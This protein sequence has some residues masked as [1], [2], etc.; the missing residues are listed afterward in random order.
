MITIK[1][2][3]KEAGVAISTVSNILNNPTGKIKASE[4]TQKKV[5][6][7]V[8]KYG[9]K[10]CMF[11]KSLRDGR[12]YTVAVVGQTA[13]Y[14]RNIAYCLSGIE[15]YLNELSYSVLFVSTK[16]RDTESY[17]N[18]IEKILQRKIDGVIIIEKLNEM[19]LEYFKTLANQVPTI[20]VFKD[21]G[22]ENIKSV[23]V[24]GEKIGRLGAEYLYE[25]GHRKV[26]LLGNRP[27]IKETLL[28][29]WGE[30]GLTLDEKYFLPD[31]EDFESG[32][33]ALNLVVDGK[34]DATAIFCYNDNNAAG[35]LY[36]AN[37]LKVN[38]PAEL[39]VLGVNNLDISEKIYPKLTTIEI[40]NISQGIE[41]AR[42]LMRVIDK[43]IAHNQ[44][45]A[46]TLI[47]R[48]SCKKIKI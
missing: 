40:P 10:P 44:I 39:S 20:K 35:V 22:V 30:H 12:S 42:L 34:I 25:L 16:S 46:P 4:V 7:I 41:A 48:D 11:G 24:D 3:A 47:E 43:K 14:D 18:C 9:Y 1:E 38:V 27:A 2:I 28:K 5:L 19:N 17:Q 13:H 36:E 23:Y 21:S 32:R 29:V 26:L 33:K 31:F 37:R 6:E 45:L 8:E 15:E